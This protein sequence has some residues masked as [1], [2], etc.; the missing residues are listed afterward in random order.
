MSHTKISYKII[1]AYF[2]RLDPH[3]THQIKS[4][5]I[6]DYKVSWLGK[7]TSLTVCIRNFVGLKGQCHEIF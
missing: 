1:T 3:R 4:Y 2:N 6:N 5:K 7:V